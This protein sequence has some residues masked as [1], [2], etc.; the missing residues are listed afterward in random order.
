MLLAGV[1][2]LMIFRAASGPQNGDSGFGSFLVLLDAF[3]LFALHL[4]IVVPFAAW[5]GTRRGTR[6]L[7][8]Q[9]LVLVATL[10]P[11]PVCYLVV[12]AAAPPSSQ[13]F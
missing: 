5:R 4:A 8:L 3:A 11:A 2:C 6:L 1:E 13:V 7:S 12:R 10:V 9:N